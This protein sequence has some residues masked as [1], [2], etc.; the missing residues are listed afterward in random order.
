MFSR[1]DNE[2]LTR[3]GPGS[4]MG[5]LM[6]RYWIPAAFSRQLAQ[7]DGPP[8]RVR[9]MGENL[10][11]FRTT[12]GRVGL[13]DERCPH[14]LAS[15]F[16]GRNEQNGLRCVYHGLKFDVDGRCVDAPCVPNVSDEQLSN[17]KR[18]LTVKSY[19]CV[20]RGDIIWAYMGPPELKPEFPE[21]EWTA[22]PSSHR[23]ATRHLQE[24]N[25]LQ[26]VEGGFDPTHLDFLHR[27][28]GVREQ[29]IVPSFY[30]VIPTDFGFAFGA[31]R[32]LGNGDIRWSINVMLMPFHKLIAMKLNAAHVWVPIDDKN[33]MV[34][35]V[36]FNRERPLTEEEIARQTSW[37]DIHPEN[38]PGTDRGVQNKSNDYLIDR[39]RQS[40]GSNFTGMKGVGTQDCAIQ[41]SM[42]PIVDR[43]HEHLLTIDSH[44]VKVRRLLLQALNDYAAGKT[45]PGL[46]PASYRVKTMNYEAP[47][48]VPFTETA[49]KH[50]RP[51]EMATSA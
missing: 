4:P 41:E 45:P 29:R 44:V 50:Y 17:I 18:A 14:R 7:P 6:R 42:G 16:F 13:V 26:G 30:E 31:G 19:P 11:A 36:H 8:L 2:R 39:A 20:E 5:E 37:T 3:V 33:T 43:A 1:E 28:D 23:F 34:Y 27:G 21:L 49:Y 12:D 15:L 40:S 22:V 38:I 51:K 48:G 24:C 25:W 10:V 46:D 35:S 47:K 9:L 32:D